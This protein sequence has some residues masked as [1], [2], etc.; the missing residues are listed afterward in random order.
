MAW[1]LF[2]ATDL[3]LANLVC[4]SLVLFGLPGT[5]LMLALSALVD[6]YTETPLFAHSTLYAAAGIAA[7]GEVLEFVAGSQGARRAG[8]G[9]R[10]SL[11]ALVGGLGGAL[12]GTFLIP[13]P[14][15]GS[16]VGAALGAFALATALEHGGGQDLRSAF[17][18]G[19]GAA[20]GQVTGTFLK[21]M[22]GVSVWVL[23][24]V[25]SFW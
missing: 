24:T 6:H 16:L 25:A 7:L 8:A 14:V 5:W 23:L 4:L 12:V 21:L 17:R 3:A 22:L 20:I 2:L 11:G 19:R 1:K 15:V 9:R 10:G 13:I 18:A